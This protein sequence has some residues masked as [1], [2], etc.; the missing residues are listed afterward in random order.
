MNTDISNATIV[1]LHQAFMEPDLPDQYVIDNT[2]FFTISDFEKYMTNNNI[3][4]NSAKTIWQ[5][6]IK[7]N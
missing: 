1:M 7:Q 5:Q 3:K 4:L 2:T 6:I